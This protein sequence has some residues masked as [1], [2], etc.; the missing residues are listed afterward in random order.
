MAYPIFTS[1]TFP[2]RQSSQAKSKHSC[3]VIGKRGECT[4]GMRKAMD[5]F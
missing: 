3:G 5:D 4:T 1:I 2:R